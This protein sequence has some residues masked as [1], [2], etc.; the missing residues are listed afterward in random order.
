V[1]DVFMKIWTV[2]E[3]MSGINNFKHFLLVV[4][5]NQAFD[6]LKKQLKEHAVRGINCQ[7]GNDPG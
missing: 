6:V 5:R 1:Q 3:T 2:W 7:C 4:S